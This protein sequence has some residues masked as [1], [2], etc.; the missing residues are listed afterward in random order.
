MV[1]QIVRSISIKIPAG[2]TSN[3][4]SVTCERSPSRSNDSPSVQG[5]SRITAPPVEQGTEATLISA[6]KGD[7]LSRVPHFT[8]IANFE[9]LP[10]SSLAKTFRN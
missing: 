3:R 4:D 10:N 1:E 7:P 5:I 2:I 9:A 6:R 8:A